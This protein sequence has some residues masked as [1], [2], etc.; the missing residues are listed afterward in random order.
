VALT[1]PEVVVRKWLLLL[2]VVVGLGMALLA[3]FAAEDARRTDLLDAARAKAAY[4][5]LDRGRVRLDRAYRHE[6]RTPLRPWRLDGRHI[7]YD[8]DNGRPPRLAT[9]DPD[10]G[11]RAEEVRQAQQE[12]QQALGEL[13]LLRIERDRRHQSWPARL[14]AE[15]RR[16]VGW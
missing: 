9:D 10:D 15:V 6:E 12:V 7:T 14:R 2:A 5:R 3:W 16:R 11:A 8:G 13:A 1:V 4:D